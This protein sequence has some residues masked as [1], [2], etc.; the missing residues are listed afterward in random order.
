MTMKKWII[1]CVAFCIGC[2]NQK[3]NIPK[4]FDQNGVFKDFYE[5]A[6]QTL[7]SMSL[8]EKVGQLLLVRLPKDASPIIKE[9]QFG[10]IVLFGKDFENKTKEQVKTELNTYQEVS[11]I[12]L[13]IATDEEGG[14][15][16]RISKNS[17]LYPH[18][19]ESSREIYEKSGMN[20]ILFDTNEKIKLLKELGLNVNLSPVVDLASNPSA[21][22]YKRSFSGSAKE[23]S[24]YV[25]QVVTSYQKSHIGSVLKHFPGYGENE[26]TH[27]GTAIDKR[28]YKQFETNDFL[29]FEEGIKAGAPSILV[30]H[31]IVEA[32]DKNNPASLSKKVHQI[33][34]EDLE[35]HGVIMTDDLAMGAIAAIQ[36]STVKAFQAGNDLLMVTDYE[37]AYQE[38]YN[39]FKKQE[40]TLD[41]LNQSVLRILAWKYQLQLFS[42]SD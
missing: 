34:R 26:D 24:N 19:F 5:E 30:S 37:T 12:P 42:H 1:L 3:T 16:V 7:E 20:G 27:V 15:V 6:Y 29:P 28:S 38:L 14:S 35:F 39:A 25:K 36:E 9:K 17:N 22:I 8:E 10:G 32:M 21:F 11:K 2:S 4:Q 23:T 41:D 31:N 40:L 13:L 33:L 18:K